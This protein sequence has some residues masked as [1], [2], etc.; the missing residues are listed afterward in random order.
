MTT[1]YTPPDVSSR[2]GAPMG[3]HASGQATRDAC[4]LQRMPLDSGGYD[5]GGA[6]WGTPSN[7]WVCLDDDGEPICY[8]RAR[9]RAD[10]FDNVCDEIGSVKLKRGVL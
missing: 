10:A 1:T 8:T 3:R 9:D 5:A 7:L 6:Y 4:K 2:Y